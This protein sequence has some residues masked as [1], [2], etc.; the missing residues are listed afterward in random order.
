MVFI[1]PFVHSA[2]LP[3]SLHYV[4]HTRRITLDWSRRG[5]RD[6]SGSSWTGSSR[7]SSTEMDCRYGNDPRPW[8][9]TDSDSS[10][11]WTNPAAKPRQAANHSWD[12]RSTGGDLGQHGGGFLHPS[13]GWG[14]FLHPS[15]GWGGFLATI[16]GVG[17]G[18]WWLLLRNS[19]PSNYP[20]AAEVL[21]VRTELAAQIFTPEL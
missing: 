16:R 11:Q 9:S 15:E 20:N 14:G 13:V 1:K 5:S 18:V 12:G 2:R 17:G 19:V 7:Q 10:Y 21:G 4:A 3:P 6:S 8:S